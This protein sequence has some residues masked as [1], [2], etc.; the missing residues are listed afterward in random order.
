MRE[1]YTK[2]TGKKCD[3]VVDEE[4]FLPL[5]RYILASLVPSPS[6]NAGFDHLQYVKQRGKTWECL[7][8]F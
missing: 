2:E 6:H 7:N 4:N 1:A 3:I 8:D 5:D